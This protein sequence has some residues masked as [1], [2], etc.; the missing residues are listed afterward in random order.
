MAAGFS[1]M[2]HDEAIL[3]VVRQW[4][5][6]AGQDLAACEI[7]LESSAMLTGITAFHAQQA[8][9]KYIKA[10]LA[11][12]EISFPKTHNIRHLLELL[13][14]TDSLLGESLKTAW[15]LSPYGVLPRYPGDLPEIPMAEAR[16]LYQIAICV[17]DAVLGSI[18]PVR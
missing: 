8:A 15:A 3:G 5:E 16:R 10:L 6:K 9:E 1:M 2:P 17:R 14:P 4:I 18:P 11:L 13:G 12:R 7:L